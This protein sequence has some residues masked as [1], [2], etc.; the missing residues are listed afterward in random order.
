MSLS[1]TAVFCFE[2]SRESIWCK[3]Q[4]IKKAINFIPERISRLNEPNEDIYRHLLAD[5]VSYLEYH[6]ILKNK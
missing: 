3:D 6:F 5:L 2:Q 1:S 4:F